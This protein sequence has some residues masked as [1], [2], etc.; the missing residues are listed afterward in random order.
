MSDPFGK[1][2]E[3]VL[4]VLSMSR[5]RLA[6]DLGVDKSVVGRWVTG[7]VQPSAHNLSLLSALIATRIPGFNA[8]DWDRSLAAFAEMVGADLEAVSARNPASLAMGLPL[9]GMDQF[10]AASALRGQAYEGFFRSTRPYVMAPG[11]FVHDHAIV[12]R[13]PNGLLRVRIGTGGTVVDGWV[14][15]M[16]SQL[17]I[18]AIDVISGA[19]LFGL[20]NGV[21]AARADVVDGLVLAPSLDAGRTPTA[22]AIIFERIGDLTG[23]AE[24]DDRHFLEL[25]ARDP[26]APDG[27]VPDDLRSHLTGDFGPKALASGGDMLLQMPVSRSRARGPAYRESPPKGG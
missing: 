19:V 16:G 5:A 18:V 14:L 4:K 25:A 13:D 6:A 2:L 17:Y 23:D 10:L 11:R 3:L 8:L 21:G 15:L 26:V 24:A 12:R 20:F 9:V 7:S 1:K 27:T 22:H